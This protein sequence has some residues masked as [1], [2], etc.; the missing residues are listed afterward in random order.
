MLVLLRLLVALKLPVAELEFQGP[1]CQCFLISI[2]VPD[3]IS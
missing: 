1:V 3:S 2:N